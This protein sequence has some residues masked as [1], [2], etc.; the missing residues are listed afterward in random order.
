MVAATHQENISFRIGQEMTR[1][2]EVAFIND[3]VVR[4]L[5]HRE[6]VWRTRSGNHGQ[7]ALK[8]RPSAFNVDFAALGGGTVIDSNGAPIR[9]DLKRL[10]DSDPTVRLSLIARLDDWPEY[11]VTLLTQDKVA[12]DNTVTSDVT[13]V[14]AEQIVGA[15]RNPCRAVIKFK[16]AAELF[17]LLF[18]Q[19]GRPGL[20]AN[21]P[22]AVLKA[23]IDRGRACCRESEQPFI[24]EPPVAALEY[25]ASLGL[26]RRA[27]SV[28][29]VNVSDR[30]NN[31][32]SN[33][34]R[35]RKRAI[36][37][38][39]RVVHHRAANA[40]GHVLIA[41]TAE[42][43]IDSPYLPSGQLKSALVF[44]NQQFGVWLRVGALKRIQVPA[45]HFEAASDR[46]RGKCG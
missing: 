13:V 2:L 38:H 36:V 43:D 30:T 46:E 28:R 15:V 29:D 39:A 21:G 16:V 32:R 6:R 40:P 45:R 41:R 1:G 31:I 27:T 7:Y 35:G 12:V 17:C 44:R 23:G 11:I 19:R 33:H 3:D 34:A 25:K 14:D 10:R 37:I 8:V 5:T 4:K 18:K 26:K 20:H 42:R 9:K 24:F 22:A